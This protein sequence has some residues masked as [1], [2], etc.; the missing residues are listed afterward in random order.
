MSVRE[1]RI[2]VLTGGTGGAKL[3]RGLDR[4]LGGAALTVIVNTGDDLDCWGLHVSPDIDSVTY[5]LA[6]LLSRGRGWGIEADTFNCLDQ[7]RRLGASAWF[8]LGDR[9]LAL[10]LTR[11]QMLR[12]G[13]TL[14]ETTA[15]IT[16]ALALAAR[17]LPMSD[18]RVETRVL[19]TKGELSFQQYFVRERFQPEVESVRFVGAENA[20]PAPD[21]LAAISH[22]TAVVIAPSN[23]IT[24]IGPILAVPGIRD[25]LRRSHAP[26]IAVSPIVSGAAVS[27]PAGNLMKAAGL[28]VSIEGVAIAYA[29]FLDVLI[30][31]ALDVGSKLRDADAELLFTETIMRSDEDKLRLA[32]F[33][34]DAA[35]NS[36][37]KAA[38]G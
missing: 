14:T 19:T 38:V 20:K 15:Q 37:G 8:Q 30:A 2:V 3:V 22:A 27:G 25:A 5:A 28:P 34:I 24:S 9:D 35:S 29:D 31:D 4:A 33:V 12:D 18:D 7:M 21:V 26:V 16:Q 11:T 10:H 1:H 6:D 17:I 36:R 32:E 13:R 23:P